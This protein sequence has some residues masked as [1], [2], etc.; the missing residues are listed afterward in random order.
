MAEQAA[1]M[2]AMGEEAPE[3]A[4][5][6]D[7]VRRGLIG[8]PVLVGVC[9]GVWGFDGLWSSGYAL[10]LILVNFWLAASLITWSMRISPTMLMAGVM[11]GYFIRLGILTGAYF[12]VR[13]TGW[14]EALP[15]V[16]T[17]VAAHIV[18]L[19]WETRYVSMSLAYPGLKPQGATQ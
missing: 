11:G 10:G 3:R 8:G 9:A 14:F 6:Q 2:P 1:Q 5:A 19:V 13:N 7:M 18:L 4:L 16:I 15:F 12:L 17:L